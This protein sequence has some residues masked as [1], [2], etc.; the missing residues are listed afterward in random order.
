MSARVIW[1]FS[2]RGSA[3]SYMRAALSF[4]ILSFCLVAPAVGCT[5]AASRTA[6]DFDVPSQCLIGL[7]CEFYVGSR[8]AD[9][10]YL[11]EATCLEG[12]S[13]TVDSEQR[14]SSR[15]ILTPLAPTY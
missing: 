6:K 13:M 7:R 5:N 3:L 1:R 8:R 11:K 10:V 4:S 14:V 15:A 9:I 12:C 2:D